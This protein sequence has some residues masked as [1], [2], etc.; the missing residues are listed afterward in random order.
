MLLGCFICH[1][2]IAAKLPRT[3]GE[4]LGGTPAFYAQWGASCASPLPSSALRHGI[5]CLCVSTHHP[6]LCMLLILFEKQ[7]QMKQRKKEKK[8]NIKKTKPTVFQSA[9]RNGKLASPRN[10]CWALPGHGG[11]WHRAAV[12]GG[13]VTPHV[14]ISAGAHGCDFGGCFGS[15]CFSLDVGMGSQ[16]DYSPQLPKTFGWAQMMPSGTAGLVQDGEWHLAF[17]AY[18]HGCATHSLVTLAVAV[19][20][21]SHAKG[22]ESSTTALPAGAK[23]QPQTG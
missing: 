6:Q 19:T 18:V 17:L 7:L 13:T 12:P 11:A 21:A 9:E 22:A 23:P 8:N 2:S 4:K 10:L 15:Q 16:Q 1:I 14:G 20:R 3:T 5:I